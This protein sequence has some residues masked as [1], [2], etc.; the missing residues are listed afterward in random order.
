MRQLDTGRVELH[1]DAENG[2]CNILP[3]EKGPAAS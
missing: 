2:T 1:F 3:A